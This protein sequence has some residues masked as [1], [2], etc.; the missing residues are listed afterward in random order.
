MTLRLAVLS[1][2]RQDWGILRSTC[3]ALRD[4]AAFDAVAPLRIV[5][6]RTSGSPA[7][8]N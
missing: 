5:Q 4:D 2:G 7:V 6:A 8:K 1:T 3:L